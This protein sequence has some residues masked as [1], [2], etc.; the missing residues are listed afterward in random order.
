MRTLLSARRRILLVL[1][2]LALTGLFWIYHAGG[3][4]P[5][6][7]RFAVASD[8]HLYDPTL[9]TDGPVFADYVAGD[10]K[11]M[12]WSEAIFDRFLVE[13][14]A[15]EPRP[16]F[17][18]L[19]GDLT[20]DGEQHNHRR[21]AER[22]ARLEDAGIEVFVV[23]GNHD[24]DNPAAQRYTAGGAE[25]VVSLD[26]SGFAALYARFGYQQALARDR[27]SLSYVAE[28]VPGVRLLA[29]DSRV[30]V[31]NAQVGGKLTPATLEWLLVQLRRARHEGAVVLAMMH[32][33]LLEHYRGQGEF[34]PEFL[35]DNHADV[36]TAL[37]AGGLRVI[38]TGHFHA[39]DVTRRTWPDG[40]C[41]TDVE[42]GST[43]SWPS[44]YRLARLD[45]E[46]ARLS[47]TTRKIAAPQAGA[48]AA[49]EDKFPS[50][51]RRSLERQ[52]TKLVAA[53]MAEHTTLSV[54]RRT[55]LAPAVV[56][57]AL[58]HYA[59]DEV[60][61]FETFRAALK[62]ARQGRGSEVTVGRLLL[63]LWHDLPPADRTL[64]LH[65][66]DSCDEH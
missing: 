41:L 1:L 33:G 5:R 23:P 16:D 21:M 25:P 2:L 18:L 42:T 31:G 9:G 64:E 40:A 57:A 50:F 35:V 51:A 48:F 55:Q 66:E 37:A 4:T 65:L 8:P 17:L 45:P 49:A 61:T 26:S 20:K 15:L 36:S 7:V 14:W 47:L 11:L 59:G 6:P 34:F 10:I 39:Q 60:P 12:A 43:A 32:H 44:A 62:M 19:C 46:T 54:D 13:L 52:L 24:I 29:I 3:V 38:F 22:L 27:H 58:A 30:Q 53:A 28:P 63:S 56:A